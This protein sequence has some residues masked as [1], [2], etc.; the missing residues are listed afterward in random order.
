MRAHLLRWYFLAWPGT[1]L[2]LATLHSLY[3][4]LNLVY[5]WISMF[6]EYVAALEKH[7]SPLPWPGPVNNDDIVDTSLGGEA[8]SDVD[9]TLESGSPDWRHDVKAD[10]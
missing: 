4:V 5:R 6:H 8:V 9:A 1:Q 3:H 7:E 2:L 10:M